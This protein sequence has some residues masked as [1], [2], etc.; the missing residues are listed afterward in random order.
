MN[1]PFTTYSDK[2]KLYTIPTYEIRYIIFV[3]IYYYHF[4][5]WVYV[6][7][8]ISSQTFPHFGWQVFQCLLIGGENAGEDALRNAEEMVVTSK[9]FQEFC[10]R[11]K[12]IS[13]LV[14]ESNEQVRPFFHLF[15]FI[16]TYKVDVATTQRAVRHHQRWRLHLSERFW[17]EIWNTYFCYHLS[18]NYV[19]LSD[20]Y[21]VLSDLYVDLIVTCLFVRE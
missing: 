1:A 20:L 21:V 2:E 19:D 12:E 4:H 7:N 10:E 15:G 5:W 18:D 9:E 16:I 14:P 17:N 13:C 8:V 3:L 11:H 6:Y